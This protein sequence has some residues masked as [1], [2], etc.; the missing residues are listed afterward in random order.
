MRKQNRTTGAR[1]HLGN[2]QLPDERLSDYARS[3]YAQ[4]ETYQGADAFSATRYR[5]RTDGGYAE[6]APQ[7]E[8]SPTPSTSDT[9]SVSGSRARYSAMGKRKR[10]KRR[11]VGALASLAVVATLV[12]GS[13]WGFFGNLNAMLHSGLDS[14]LWSVL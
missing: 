10:R 8:N 3:G 2:G 6:T 5:D 1:R 4:P 12:A 14:S 13:A 7:R 9:Y 11:I